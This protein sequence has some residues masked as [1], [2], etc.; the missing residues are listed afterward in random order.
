ML[1]FVLLKD[2]HV[3]QLKYEITN[4]KDELDLRKRIFD[5]QLEH[6]KQMEQRII[7]A[8]QNEF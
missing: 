4:I 3:L 7:S 5:G 6:L 2:N 8:E 1:P